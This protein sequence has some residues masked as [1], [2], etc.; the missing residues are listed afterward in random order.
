MLPLLVFTIIATRT[1]LQ[2]DE[3]L[4]AP[5]KGL[6]CEYLVDPIN[7][8]S[9]SPRLSWVDESSAKNWKQ[10]AF[11]ILV[12]SSQAEIAKDLGDLWDTG[13]VLSSETTQIE[14]R[15]RSLRPR[16][17]YFWKVRVWDKSGNV[18]A[19]SQ[20]RLWEM[21]LQSEKDWHGSVWIGRN[22]PDGANPAPFLR[23]SFQVHG[24]ISRA[25]IY[26]T[27][28]GYC[29]LHV[30]GEPVGGTVERDPGY[31]DFDKRVLTVAYDVTRQL[32]SGTNA[33][34]AV[35]GTGWYD[36][37]D[38]ATWNFDRAPW[39]GR[40]RTRVLL[41][42]DY[43]DGKTQFVTSDASWKLATGPILRDGIYTG[44]VYDA[45]KEIPGWDLP[46]LDDSK[47]SSADVMEAPKGVLS[48]RPCP[49]V[50]ITESIRPVGVSEPKPAVYIV[51][52][53]QTFSG[54]VRLHVRQAKGTAITM[55]YSE[56][57]GKDGMIDRAQI[58]Q[59]MAKATPPQPFQSDTYICKGKGIE[60]WEQRFSYSGFRYVEVTGLDHKPQASEFEGRFAHT[61]LESAGEF[62]CSNELLNQIQRATRYSYF[63]NAQSIPTDCPQ[64][65]KNGWTGDAHLAAEAG[66]MNFRSESLYT[67][68]LNDL[69]DNETPDGKISVIVPTGGWGAWG[70]NPA[71]D[72]AYP[73]IVNDLLLY[74]D[75]KR[76]VR[77]HFD[78][79]ARYVDS[80]AT[81]L[82]DDVLTFDSLGDW[83]PW[84]TE[85]SS[86]L[87][88]TAFLFLDACF[89]SKAALLLGDAKASEKYSRLADRVKAGY[90]TKFWD[91]SKGTYGNASQTASAIS[92]YFGLVPEARRASVFASLVKNVETQGHIDT[93]ILGAKYVLRVLSEAGRSD[94]AYKLVARKEQPGWGWWFSQGATTLWEDWKG[95]SSLNHIMFGDV[96][97][98]F[99]QWVAGI[100]LD[101]NAPGFARVLIHPQTVGDLTWA[102][103]SFHSPHGLIRSSWRR[104]NGGVRYHV[105]VPANVTATVSLPKGPKPFEIGSGSYVY[106]VKGE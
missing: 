11:Q 28:V 81:E 100:G 86:Q 13:K 31:T 58:E 10:S 101:T 95:E 75:D 20:P 23:K 99:I 54:H 7:V 92:L 98:W 67:K 79:L 19:W 35:L 60:T 18:S 55:R 40:P 72:S 94:L 16:G 104:V 50:A 24:T 12:S 106:F 8:G 65:E 74:H 15:G 102:R 47:W 42:I 52:F 91:A 78:H 84:S 59:F 53:G 71:W 96:S 82:H 66:L 80:L 87:T 56:R 41:A 14:Y 34:G 22:A 57:L 70:R 64:R 88:S 33:I 77:E 17:R 62:E 90:N 49:P 32:K 48:A 26:A 61:D 45:T 103:A 27:G 29:E 69:K 105:T 25:S 68:W 6:R 36:V 4:S 21:G 51:D 46:R 73:I 93:G 38:K 30:N 83:V 43:S 85:T 9:S 97:N 76:V 63:S 1:D 37:H 2:F 39:R 44:E 5:P 3:E 89:V